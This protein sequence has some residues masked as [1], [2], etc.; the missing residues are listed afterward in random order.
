MHLKIET[1]LSLEMLLE[2]TERLLMRSVVHAEVDSI[3]IEL[4]V[5]QVSPGM[6]AM[7]WKVTWTLKTRLLSSIPS[8]QHQHQILHLRCKM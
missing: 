6:L 4:P 3:Q 2:Q 1:A 7:E 5:H 8:L